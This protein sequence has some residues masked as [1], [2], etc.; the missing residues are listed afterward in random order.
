MT[1]LTRRALLGASGAAGLIAISGCS[2]GF[3]DAG[4]A[5]AD[6][7]VRF[8]NWP[9]YID[10]DSPT[11]LEDFTK[12]Y[13]IRVDYTEDINDGQEFYAKVRG[14]LEQG[15]GIDRDL[16]V[17]SEETAS[18]FITLGYAESLD[19]SL[20]PNA[21]N[22]LPRL[23]EA[24]FDP[25]RAFSL[26][27]QSG[28]TG[29]GSN[30]ALIADR[31]GVTRLTS[32]E[33]FFDPRL[34]GRV[35][36]LSETMDTMGLLLQWQGYSAQSFSDDQ[37]METLE[38]LQSAIDTGQIRQVTGND[39][40]SGLASGDLVA[41]IG[42]SGDVLALGE[43]FDFALPESG[44]VV[45]ADSMLIPQGAEHKAATEKLM[46]FFYDPA[47]AARVAAYIQYSCPVAGAQEAMTTVDP[48]LVDDPWIFPSSEVLDACEVT[49]SLSLERAET[50]DRAYDAVVGA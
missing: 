20:I 38:V 2:A 50:L 8:S 26:P 10:E 13:G 45:W 27:W 19:Y 5:A 11:T 32:F 1:R 43:G 37:F 25:G 31:L 3:S 35:S 9:M 48:E 29:F 40:I 21:V 39:Y 34:K 49:A 47:V 41:A 44:G 17:F 12:N 46:N 7:P 30:T 23:R 33:Q 14:E 36:I 6:G 15:R 18:L 16:V 4:S 24:A 42:W 28:F 22:L